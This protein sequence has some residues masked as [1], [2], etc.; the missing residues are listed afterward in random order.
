MTPYSN[1]TRNFYTDFDY[2]AYYA[3]GLCFHGTQAQISPDSIS[4]N[5]SG[6]PNPL[7]LGNPAYRFGFDCTAAAGAGSTYGQPREYVGTNFIGRFT[8]RETS[9]QAFGYPGNIT[10]GNPMNMTLTYNATTGTVTNFAPATP[11]TDT[12]A[13]ED[14]LMTNVLKFDIKVWDAAASV[15]PDGKPGI[16][17]V[18]DDG[19]NG[20][21]DQNELGWPGSDDGDFRDIGHIGTTGFYSSNPRNI[22]ITM[23]YNGLTAAGGTASGTKYPAAGATIYNN[24]A[25]ALNRYDTWNSTIDFNADGFSDP[26][27]FC[28]YWFG[29]DGV[30]GK[31]GDDDGNGFADYLPSGAYDPNEV[32]WPGTDD[33]PM[34]LSAIQIKITFYDTTSKQIREVTGV[35]SLR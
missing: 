26:P 35:F 14:V 27:P 2:S 1:G 7:V 20:V 22:P 25:A 19:Y 6:V 31:V 5:Y 29:P 15:G 33:Q 11:P 13:S 9:N 30:P 3:G 18:D 32:G 28:P 4:A 16:A 8:H 34:P 21:D 12:R 17:G 10:A 23:L 24:P